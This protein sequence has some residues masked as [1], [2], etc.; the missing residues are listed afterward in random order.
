VSEHAKQYVAAIEGLQQQL[1]LLAAPTATTHKDQLEQEVSALQ[2][3]V[4]RAV[5]FA[6]ASPQ[7]SWSCHGTM[8]NTLS[9]RCTRLVHVVC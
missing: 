9:A 4:A 3:E 1:L 8:H 6:G 2:Q 5:S 7:E